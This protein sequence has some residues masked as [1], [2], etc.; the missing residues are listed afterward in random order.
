[1]VP[2]RIPLILA[3]EVAKETSRV[4]HGLKGQNGSQSL[5]FG[6]VT[7]LQNQTKKLKQRPNLRKRSLPLLRRPKTNLIKS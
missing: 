1:M 3:A 2:T 4:S 5:I 7:Y 6:Q